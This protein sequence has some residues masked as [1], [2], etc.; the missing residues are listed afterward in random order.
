MHKL[1]HLLP[2]ETAHSLAIAA[3]KNGLAPSYPTP[4]KPVE[5]FGLKFPNPIGIA[6]GFDKNAEAIDGLFGLGFGFVEV[7]TVTPRPQKGNPKPRI[8]RLPEQEAIINRLGF[9][10]A[11]IDIF[12]DN[13]SKAKRKRSGILGINIGA[14]KDTL[15]FAD[16]YAFLIPKIAHHADYITVNISSPNTPGLR[17]LQKK[18]SIRALAENA[19]KIRN[20]QTKQPP[21]LVKIAPD[22]NDDELTTIIDALM[23]AGVDGVIATNTTIAHNEKEKGGLSGEPLLEKST[24]IVRKISAQAGGKLPIIA[25][26]GVSDA[27]SAK[28]KFDAGASLVQIYTGMIYKGQKIAIDIC[29]GL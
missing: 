21:L 16:D 5:V 11:G 4:Q 10:N 27:H 22:L 2:A 25:V 23:E 20:E 24:E 19:I 6:A 13:I 18:E 26:G 1:F 3:L 14:N 15:N 7:G 8:F 28:A 9:N 12:L 29:A 17:D